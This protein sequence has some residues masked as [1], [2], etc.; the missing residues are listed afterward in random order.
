MKGLM[1]KLKGLQFKQLLIAHGEKIVLGT[2]G[3]IV[4]MALATTQWSGTDKRPDDLYEKAATAGTKLHTGEWPKDRQEKF[5]PSTYQASALAMFTKLNNTEG[6]SPYSFDKP[7]SFPLYA[8]QEPRV[9][10]AW[11]VVQHLLADAGVMVMGINT[12]PEFG[13]GEEGAAGDAEASDTPRP[14]PLKGAPGGPMGPMGPMGPPGAPGGPGMPPGMMPGMGM[15]GNSSGMKPVGQ[16]YVGVRGIVD[17]FAIGR[18]LQKAC[19]LESLAEGIASVEVVDFRIQRQKAV[20]GDNPWPDNTWQDVSL[21]R[22]DEVL[23][24]SGLAADLVNVGVTDPVY[25]MPLPTRLDGDY[26]ETIVSHPLLK[27]FQLSPEMRKLEQQLNSAILD[28]ASEMGIGEEAV[29]KRRGFLKNQIDI[30]SVRSSVMGAGANAADIYKKAGIN[31]N[32]AMGAGGMP[33]MPMMPAM[34]GAGRGGSMPPG[35]MGGPGRGGAMPPPMN[36]GMPM[37]GGRGGNMPPGMMGMGMPGM[38]GQGQGQQVGGSAVGYLML[39]RFL[40]FEVNP[41][42]AYRYRVQLEF[43]NPNYGLSLDKVKEAKVAEGETRLTEWSEP[44]APVVVKPDTNF[45]LSKVDKRARTRGEAEFQIYQWDPALGTYIDS[46]KLVAKFGQFVGGLEESDRLDLGI[47]ALEKKT[48]LF[49]T[50]DFLLDT[51]LPPALIPSENPDLNLAAT[52]RQAKEGIELPAEAAVL[53]E[54]GQLKILDSISERSKVTEDE[55]KVKAER[56]PFESL[57]DAGGTETNDLNR[58]GAG[59][60]GGSAGMMMMMMGGPASN[61]K[62]SGKGAKSGAPMGGP[63]GYGGGY[64]AGAAGKSKKGAMGYPGAGAMPDSTGKKKPAR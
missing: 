61:L 59:P 41:G 32:A 18:A 48:V 26:S 8:R 34:G 31:A 47:P 29:T 40:D 35:M 36:S 11:P 10:T 43:T 44:T 42:E 14:P 7:M 27:D 52:G 37:M 63:P 21:D 4:L 51:A 33:M 55:K 46:K 64:G 16:R 9:E 13:E 54:Y 1:A 38:G 23:A 24:E 28:T 2:V 30:N 19:H 15:S 50:K 25:T 20:A 60:E 62:R 39:F 6:M 12:T 17:L 45:Y 49:A 53:D 3:L 58:L 57:R 56:D 22:A 5:Q